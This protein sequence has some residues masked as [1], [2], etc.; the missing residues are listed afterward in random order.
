MP[1]NHTDFGTGDE[2]APEVLENFS[3][4]GSG[5]SASLSG[6]VG[7]TTKGGGLVS[8][9][10]TI[11]WSES[12]PS[13]SDSVIN[14]TGVLNSEWSNISNPGVSA[15]ETNSIDIGGN[16]D[17][18]GPSTNNNPVLTVT[19]QKGETEASLS[20]T[21]VNTGL[22]GEYEGTLIKAEYSVS[23]PPKTIDSFSF[24]TGAYAGG[25]PTG[26]TEIRI[27]EES[28]DGTY[29]EGTVVQTINLS[30]VSSNTVNSYDVNPYSVSENVDEIT[31]E[32]VTTQVSDGQYRHESAYFQGVNKGL[33]SGATSLS[34]SGN[35]GTSVSFG[36]LSV[37]ESK[38]AEF[39]TS[40]STTELDFSA[41][42]AFVSYDLKLK[43]RSKTVDPVVE[44]N[45]DSSQQISIDGSVAAGQTVTK[46]IDNSW[47]ES[48][49]NTATVT[50]NDSGLDA[51]D[52]P[53]EAKVSV[54][55]AAQSA[56]YVS[57]AYN[58]ISRSNGVGID[59]SGSGTLDVTVQGWTGSS[60]EDARQL[61]TSE[62]GDV[63]LNYEPIE[64]EQTRVEIVANDNVEIREESIQFFTSTPEI[65]SATPSSGDAVSESPVELSINVS[66]ADF[67]TVQGDSVDVTFYD[68]SDDSQIGTDTLSGNGTATA[69]WGTLEG[70][71][72][73]WYAVASDSYGNQVT[74]QTFT[75]NAPS[76]LR[77][78]NES[79]PDQLV[80]TD[81]DVEVT[82]FSGD[83]VITRTTS[84]GTV[85]LS[86]LPAD[87]TFTVQ[88]EASGYVTRQA[89]INGI[90]EQQN[91]YLLPESVQ[92][93]ATRFTIDDPTGQF[94]SSNTRIAVKK[95]IT[96]NGSTEY[97]IVVSDIAGEGGYATILQQDQ[98][99]LLEVT[100]TE[101]GNTRSLGPYVATEAQTVNLRIEALDFQFGSNEAGYQ[102]DAAYENETEPAI[103][104]DWKTTTATA[105][106]L[107]VTI[108]E[109]GG[110]GTVILDES[111]TE[112]D[113][114]SELAIIGN[115]VENPQATT[116]LVEWEATLADGNTVSGSAVAGPSKLPVE[117]PNVPDQVVSVLSIL[118]IL[119]VAG[120]FSAANVTVGAIVTSLTAG[121]LWFVG[122]TPGAVTGGLVSLALFV[123][124]IA[125]LRT[126]Q[127]ISPR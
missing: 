54:E 104:F 48:G 75:F 115:S 122:A 124:V 86:G 90:V 110:D 65:G 121:G 108:R 59:W 58:N 85:D 103:S 15:G 33:A 66:D 21:N 126:N 71:S 118:V 18:I 68:A 56:R 63:V 73:S 44:L 35:D 55:K 127:Q 39:D 11:S 84:D 76:T 81:S 29:E 120:L 89:V 52:P 47:L 26:S 9:G 14:V 117:M 20:Q 12:S 87:E 2:P 96:R 43:E 25:P 17:P 57:A 7:G 60:W 79:N 83:Q 50:L 61:S 45:G 67:G 22:V 74:S 98:R 1:S 113:Q 31:I 64:Y 92:S 77:L 78:L 53:M 70:G 8:S 112:P 99:Y 106:T 116:W 100:N 32:L 91:I 111:Y 119:L 95:P 16:S 62:T 93:V 38:T 102:W 3:V 19:G 125:H 109:R 27:V 41:T 10:D 80:T 37:G 4:G 6:P 23:N 28:P 114:V 5:D 34:V 107:D 72:N 94:A 105:Q 42:E 36:D 69:N 123:A 24:G 82:F 40:T 46:E 13:T 101:N 88:V 97:E 30:T 49:E 51:D